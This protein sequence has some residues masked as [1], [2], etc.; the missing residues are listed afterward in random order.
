MVP[1]VLR[2]EFHPESQLWHAIGTVNGAQYR[3]R[4]RI[5]KDI[6]REYC[7]L[8]DH[9]SRRWQVVKTAAGRLLC[10]EIP[11]VTSAEPPST[12]EIPAFR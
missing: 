7:D 2:L 11:E 10:K 9:P 12:V 6:L 5:V 3:V 8:L 4:G 1:R